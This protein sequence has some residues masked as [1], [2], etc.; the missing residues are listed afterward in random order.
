MNQLDEEGRALARK[1]DKT[2]KNAALAV[3]G[4]ILLVPY[5]FMDLKE[6]EKEELNAVRARYMHLTKLY[7]K[8]AC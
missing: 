8:K 4:Q 5:F 6:G 1:S 7:E 2:G 3:A